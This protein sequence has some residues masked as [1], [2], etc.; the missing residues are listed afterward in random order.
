GV[1][2]RQA[3]DDRHHYGGVLLAETGREGH[4]LVTLGH[5]DEA[6]GH[7]EILGDGGEGLQVLVHE[8]HLEARLE[9]ARH[10]GAR[11]ALES[12]AAAAA[13]LDHLVHPHGV[14]ARLHAHGQP[15]HHGEAV[16]AG[17][18]VVDRLHDVAGAHGSHVE[19]VRAH[20]VEHGLGLGE[21]LAVASDHD[22]EGGRTG[23][24]DTAAHGRLEEEHSARLRLGLDLSG[25]RGEYAA[26]VYQD[27]TGFGPLDEAAG[28]EVPRLDVR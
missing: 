18:H 2:G 23:S 22:G 13:R 27:R 14:E 19:D 24:A 12:L 3:L 20:G 7:V 5:V 8:G 11:D 17:H 9:L 21:R 28:I 26:E 4:L 15:F 1:D 16:D 10:D 25:R 6:H